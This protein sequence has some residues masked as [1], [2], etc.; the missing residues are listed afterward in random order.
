MNLSV[1]GSPGTVAL[2]L[3]KVY[4]NKRKQNQIYFSHSVKPD[5]NMC[6][7]IEAW[8]PCLPCTTVQGMS[9]ILRLQ[10]INQGL[11]N[12]SAP[13]AQPMSEMLLLLLFVD[14]LS[15]SEA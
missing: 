11:T 7:A 8:W 9:G 2:T 12:Q 15:F 10:Q 5:C 6:Q 13:A 1:C 14:V 4:C 3:C